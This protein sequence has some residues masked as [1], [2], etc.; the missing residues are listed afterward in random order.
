[1]QLFLIFTVLRLRSLCTLG[2]GGKQVSNSLRNLLLMLVVTWLPY[3]E[4]EPCDAE[5]CAALFVC[6]LVALVCMYIRFFNA[7]F[8]FCGS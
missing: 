8:S 2:A 4:D 1:M 5:L 6:S 3:G 7:F